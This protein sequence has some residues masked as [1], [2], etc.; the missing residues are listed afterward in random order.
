MKNKWQINRVGLQNFWYYQD[1]VFEFAQGKLLLRGSNG[2]G[3]S[4]T[5]QSLLPP[6]LDGITRANRLDSFGSTSRKIEDYLLG[7]EEVSG[8]DE[9]TGYLFI[10]YKKTNS[11]EY[12]TSGMGLNFKRGGQLRKWFFAIDD[13]SRIGMDFNL[14]QSSVDGRIYL[15]RL[16]LKNLIVDGKHGKLFDD[17][18]SYQR[19]INDRIFGF[20]SMEQYNDLIQLLIR[21]RAPKL[22]R[23]FKPSVIYEILQS[24][25]P[26]LDSDTL[27][28][29]TQTIQNIDDN[30]DQ[31][32][33][34]LDETKQL[35]RFLRYYQQYQEELTAQIAQNWL[36]K[37]A[38]VQ[39]ISAKLTQLKQSIDSL[40]KEVIQKEK[41]L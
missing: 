34:L 19:Y 40:N 13:H 14:Y 16:Q 3:K 24:S 23:D 36:E 7:E 27:L 28:P 10:E 8:K 39:D 21:L 5:T 35:S 4:V 26:V 33:T 20:Q 41:Q 17:A 18:K 38:I 31:L 11:E 2:S 15:S 25:L 30:H 1:Q 12:F 9:A 6:L 32:D 22:S 37:D 29:L